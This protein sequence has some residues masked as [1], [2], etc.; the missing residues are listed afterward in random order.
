METISI[1]SENALEE[2]S[3]KQLK[4][5][6]T[7][8]IYISASGDDLTGDGSKDNPYKTVK[9]GIE[10]SNNQSIIYLSEGNFDA[11]NISIDKTLTI[12]GVK[13][14]TV[15]DANHI[16]RI[17]FM[18]SDAKLT[19][20]RLTLINGN[21]SNNETGLGGSIYNDGG[22]LTLIN[23]TIKDSY[24]GLNGGAIYN[25]MGKLS[26]IESDIINNTAV[27]YGGAIY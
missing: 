6:N 7:N 20:I 15:I 2:N 26:L 17:F 1:N 8:T 4:D 12:E 5:A 27:Q 3:E 25:N 18:T 21:M 19:L 9:Q 11:Q 14:K 24:S 10:N 16:S 22:E 23:C 13:D